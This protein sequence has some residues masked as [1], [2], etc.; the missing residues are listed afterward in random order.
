MYLLQKHIGK[1][2]FGLIFIYLNLAGSCTPCSVWQNLQAANQSFV[3]DPAYAQARAQ[4]VGGQNP[5]TIVLSCSDSRV[6]PEL[7]FNQGLGQ[8]FVARVAGNVVD[9]VVVDSIEYAVG[10]FDSVLILVMGHTHCGAVIGAL[11]RL[12]QNGGNIVMPG[13]HLDAVLIPIEKA[14]KQAGIDIYAP[15]ALELSINANI[16][17]QANQLVMQSKVIQNALTNGI[18]NI[19]GVLY[20]LETGVATQLFVIP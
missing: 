19:V 13:G 20:S 11:N 14:I 3:N 4:L 17:Y 9:D 18:L 12:R 10:H 2:V 1:L 15:N 5:L 16:Q 7:V 6:P 8:L